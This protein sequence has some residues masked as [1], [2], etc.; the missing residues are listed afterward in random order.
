ML[1]FKYS[2]ALPTTGEYHTEFY[3]V[4]YMNDRT[5]MLYFPD[6]DSAASLKIFQDPTSQIRVGFILR[7]A[8]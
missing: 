3:G 4:D 5:L 1:E 7:R 6:T 8:S 2:K